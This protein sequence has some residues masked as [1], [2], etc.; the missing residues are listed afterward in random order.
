MTTGWFVRT[1]SYSADIQRVAS[2]LGV[3]WFVGDAVDPKVSVWTRLHEHERERVRVFITQAALSPYI[4]N[5]HDRM[6]SFDIYQLFPPLL[7]NLFG[8][9]SFRFLKKNIAPILMRDCQLPTAAA[10]LNK[11]S[12]RNAELFAA[13]RLAGTHAG[14]YGAMD[15]A[16]NDVTALL[17]RALPH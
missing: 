3:G 5:S 2:G 10:A 8:A 15:I 11:V 4:I 13:T 6:A 9:R 16:S 12:P 7:L 14:M 17:E 1:S